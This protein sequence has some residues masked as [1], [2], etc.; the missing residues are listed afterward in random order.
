MLLFVIHPNNSVSWRELLM[1]LLQRPFVRSRNSSFRKKIVNGGT[2]RAECER[3]YTAACQDSL[4]LF[5]HQMLHAHQLFSSPWSSTCISIYVINDACPSGAHCEERPNGHAQP[6][7]VSPCHVKACIWCFYC[8]CMTGW[9]K[10][11]L[12]HYSDSGHRSY[13]AFTCTVL[14][15]CVTGTAKWQHVPTEVCVLICWC[16]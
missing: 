7:I 14:V 16:H 3:Y 10:T 8:F 1:N 6:V 5:I 12:W 13:W 15:W 11:W 2:F 9:W 4:R